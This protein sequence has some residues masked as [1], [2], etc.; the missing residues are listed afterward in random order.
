MLK[1]ASLVAGAMIALAFYAVPSP[2]AES[3]CKSIDFILGKAA[4][5]GAKPIAMHGDLARAAVAFFNALEPV[6]NFDGDVAL[7]HEFPGGNAIL[8]V[9]KGTDICFSARMAKP[10]A[11]KFKADVPGEPL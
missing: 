1:L 11:D 3:Q 4:E 6:S 7:W 2:A 10:I 5:Q 8:L 9:G